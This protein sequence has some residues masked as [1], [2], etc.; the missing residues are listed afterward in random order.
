[1]RLEQE[2]TVDSNT[3]LDMTAKVRK[4]RI[5]LLIQP[6]S[7]RGS[8]TTGMVDKRPVPSLMELVYGHNWAQL[9]DE[10]I[11]SWRRRRRKKKKTTTTSFLSLEKS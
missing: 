1:M 11:I 8:L 6:S 5:V 4:A 2:D 7:T 9:G 10:D 3:N